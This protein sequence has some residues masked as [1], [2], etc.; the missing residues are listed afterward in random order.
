MDNIELAGFSMHRQDREATRGGVVCLFVNI[1]WCAMSN[2]KEVSRYC[3]PE[4]EYLMISFRPHYIR[5]ML[6]VAFYFSPQINTGT[7]TA[8]NKLYSAIT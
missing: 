3:S 8:L 2:T 6:F 4:V 1:N 7:K 5:Y